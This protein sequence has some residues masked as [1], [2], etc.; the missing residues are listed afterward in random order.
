MTKQT[1]H[2]DIDTPTKKEVVERYV[3]SKTCPT[4][5]VSSVQA[6]QMVEDMQDPDLVVAIC[7]NIV[8]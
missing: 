8:S 2:T 6:S 5:I 4:K 7:K 1:V 3:H